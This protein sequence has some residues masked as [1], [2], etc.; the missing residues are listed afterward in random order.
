MR[1]SPVSLAATPGKGEAGNG[2]IADGAGPGS[3][4]HQVTNNWRKVHLAGRDW[5]ALGLT[6]QYV[7]AVEQ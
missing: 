2:D 6:Q 5:L 7:P 3:C 1:D 4:S